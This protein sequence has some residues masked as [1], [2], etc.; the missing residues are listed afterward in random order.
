MLGD[1]EAGRA[2]RAGYET[3]G[4]FLT[5]FRLAPRNRRRLQLER[6]TLFRPPF[7]GVYLLPPA[8]FQCLYG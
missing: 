6:Y 4:K 2:F 5:Y 7:L 8:E 3:G 1:L